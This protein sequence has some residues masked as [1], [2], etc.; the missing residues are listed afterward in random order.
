MERNE[1]LKN[2]QRNV[3]KTKPKNKL[4]NVKEEKRM[5]N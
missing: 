5:I 1:I 4:Q 2:L 3:N